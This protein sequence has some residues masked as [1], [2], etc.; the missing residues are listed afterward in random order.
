MSTPKKSKGDPNSPFK[1]ALAMATRTLAGDGTLN[2]VYSADIP[3]VKG[4]PVPL[5]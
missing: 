4:A 3:G 1:Q 2:V 5:P